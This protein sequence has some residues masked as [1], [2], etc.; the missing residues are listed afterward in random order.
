MVQTLSTPQRHLTTEAEKIS[1]ISEVER[2]INLN[3]V[4]FQTGFV[5]TGLKLTPHYG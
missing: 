4:E 2:L 5:D 1:A 3:E